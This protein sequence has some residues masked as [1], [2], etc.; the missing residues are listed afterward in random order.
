MFDDENAEYLVLVNIE[1]QYSLWPKFKDVPTGWSVVGPQGNKKRC[2]D[3]IEET[4]TDM[5]P[6]SLIEKMNAIKAAESK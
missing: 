5:R 3:W 1:G 6:K 2:L 4:W